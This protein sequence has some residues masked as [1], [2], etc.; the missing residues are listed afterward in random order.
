[1]TIQKCGCNTFGIRANAP[2][3]ISAIRHRRSVDDTR[4]STPYIGIGNG[5]FYLSISTAVH[6]IMHI[7]G[8]GTSVVLVPLWHHFS[9]MCFSLKSSSHASIEY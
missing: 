1:M 6:S 4:R 8:I 2:G 9:P 5:T 7:L 3:S